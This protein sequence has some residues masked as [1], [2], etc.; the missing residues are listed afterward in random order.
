MAATDVAIMNFANRLAHARSLP[1]RDSAERTYNKLMRTFAAQV[2]AL[3]RY[4]S[5]SDNKVVFQ[6]VQAIVGDVSRPA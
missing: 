3:Q 2:E 1:E 5:K 6:H 4:R